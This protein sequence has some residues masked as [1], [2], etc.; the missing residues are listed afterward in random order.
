[1]L[2]GDPQKARILDER[3]SEMCCRELPGVHAEVGHSPGRTDSSHRLTVDDTAEHGSA[4]H[5][6]AG[7]YRKAG[8]QS[9]LSGHGRSPSGMITP[10]REEDSS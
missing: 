1:M 8:R 7:W 5:W 2:A 9:K 4:T 6:A 10:L 3:M